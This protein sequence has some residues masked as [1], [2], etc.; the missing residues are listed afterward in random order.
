MDKKKE[1]KETKK[2]KDR[3]MNNSCCYLV[4]PCGCYT[5]DASGCMYTDPCRC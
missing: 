5:F 4:D 1:K 3:E 2:G